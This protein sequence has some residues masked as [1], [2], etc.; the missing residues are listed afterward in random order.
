VDSTGATRFY[1]GDHLGSS[2][3]ITDGAGQ[4][5]EVAEYTPYG[6][7]AVQQG[8][9]NV[10]HKF[11]GQ[12][13]DT[14]TGLYFYHARYYD[15]QLGRFT[16]PDTIVQAPG[17]P[18]SLN[19]YAYARN[20][21]VKYVDP[22]GYGFWDW[23]NGVLW[24]ILT[25]VFLIASGASFY[26]GNY[27]M[28]S[29]YFAAAMYSANQSAASFKAAFSDSSPLRGPPGVGNADPFLNP[30]GPVL[31]QP[32]SPG[33]APGP[34]IS[35]LP[36]S[37]APTESLAEA[38]EAALED[39]GLSPSAAKANRHTFPITPDITP[40]SHTL[41]PETYGGPKFKLARDK[42]EVPGWVDGAKWLGEALDLSG[43]RT[44][45]EKIDFWK[46]KLY[47]KT[48]EEFLKDPGQF[49]IDPKYYYF[50]KNLRQ[51]RDWERASLDTLKNA[52]QVDQ[53]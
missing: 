8:S 26:E 19:R 18:Q 22:T 27:F 37:T 32:T 50:Y 48:I 23:I 15:P 44:G 31:L 14:S 29:V 2:N 3:V 38:A 10:A 6:S 46:N 49:F 45:E 36:S 40:P 9:S 17:D 53:S 25:V 13:L 4:L 30:E 7:L 51:Q 24:A 41:T 52:L 21:P 28:G 12:R 35:T 5:I 42:E 34:R 43:R 20:N 11:T 16:Q 1:H 47:K 39:F 33:L